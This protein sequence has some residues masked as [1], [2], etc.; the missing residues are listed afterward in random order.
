MTKMLFSS[1]Q[2]VIKV[3][4]LPDG[5]NDIVVLKNE[6]VVEH[7]EEDGKKTKMYQYDGNQ[8]RTVLQLKEEDILEDIEKWMTYDS[9]TE[10]MESERMFLSKYQESILSAIKEVVNE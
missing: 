5:K 10:I 8:F 6:E 4:P 7:I 3:I 2:E 1:P 9:S